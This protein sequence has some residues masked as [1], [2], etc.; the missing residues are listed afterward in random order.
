M[1]K[2]DGVVKKI[3]ASSDPSAF[4]TFE[5]DGE[6]DTDTDALLCLVQI[7]EPKKLFI[8]DINPNELVIKEFHVQVEKVVSRVSKQFGLTD[9]TYPSVARIEKK[10]FPVDGMTFREFQK[11]YE[12]PTVIY[13]SIFSSQQEAV[14]VDELT[15]DEFKRIG[16]KIV[17]VGDLCLAGQRVGDSADG[18]KKY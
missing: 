16:G 15:A 11:H 14:E 4:Y 17:F 6:S 12:K 9:L 2:V 13:R 5:F 7:S 1:R 18:Q 3:Q 10:E 8:V